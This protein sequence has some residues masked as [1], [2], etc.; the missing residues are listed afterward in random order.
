MNCLFVKCVFF[1]TVKKR[2]GAH[3]EELG[4]SEIH[5][6]HML[7]G[8][9]RCILSS[10][11]AALPVVVSSWVQFQTALQPSFFFGRVCQCFVM[12]KGGW[13]VSSALGPR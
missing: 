3:H 9:G 13:D 6:G 10:Q 11:S 5:P 12:G 8:Q 4:Y 1:I 7:C 2:F